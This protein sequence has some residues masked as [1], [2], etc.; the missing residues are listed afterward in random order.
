MIEWN[1]YLNQ[2]LSSS[3]DFDNITL[4]LDEGTC[5]T[6]IPPIVKAS[7]VMLDKMIEY[8]GR[9]NFMVF[10]EKKQS[11]IIF[12][13]MKLFNNILSGKI[14]SNYDPASFIAGEKLKIGNAVVE[15]L[16][17]EIRNN[18]LCLKLNL[19]DVFNFSAPMELLPVFQK[20]ETKRRL[21]KY[22]QFVAAKKDA[23]AAMRGV[24]SENEKLAYIS[25]MKTHLDS[26]IFIMSSIAAVK[27]QLADL[28]I[29]GTKATE[30]FYIAQTDYEG[31][32]TNISPGQMSGIPAIVF[33]S[34]LYAICTAVENGA[35]VQ[36]IIIDASNV[37]TLINQLDG[38]DNLIKLNVPILCITDIANSFEIKS[39]TARGFNI[40]RWGT[41]TLTDNLYETVPLSLD[42][43]VKNCANQSI[44]YLNSDGIEISAAMKLLAVHRRETEAQSPQMMRLF[45]KLSNLTFSA[46]RIINDL[47]DLDRKE[48]N[49]TL[50]ECEKLLSSEKKAIPDATTEDYLVII[51]KLYMVYE[52]G[53]L[54]KKIKV[55]Q[56]YLRKEPGKRVVLIVSEKSPRN[57]IQKY[58][59]QWCMSNS[60]QTHMKVMFPFEYYSCSM[61]DIDITVI[62][63]WMKKSIMRKLIYSFNTSQYVILLYNY[64]NEWKNAAEAHW[65]R[66]LRTSDNKRIIETAFSNGDIQVS[67]PKYIQKPVN[68]EDG[69][70]DDEIGEIE[71]ILRKNNTNRYVNKVNVNGKELVSVIPVSFVGG[72]L[73]FFRTN[74]RLISVSNIISCDSETIEIK[75]P[76]ELAVGDFIVV[77]ET[78]KDIIRELADMTLKNSGKENL[79]ELATIWRDALKIELAFCTFD[80]LYE[81]LK[82]GGC[83]KGRSTIKRWIEDEEVI[84]PQSKKDLEIIKSVTKN[85]SLIELKDKMPEAISEVRNA[86][87]IAGRKLSEQLK[88]TIAEELKKY[89]NIDP[90]IN[91]YLAW[92]NNAS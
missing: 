51:K 2:L 34:D 77:R 50:E 76:I 73:A 63:G 90:F 68:E 78:E 71:N 9:L 79:R 55:L 85:E 45:E 89:G 92:I 8:Q 64:E 18:T 6:K 53:F 16:G 49:R 35:P 48:A 65:G 72:S 40:W 74:H 3:T 10:P 5:I 14:K 60:F 80:V 22:S 36:S 13:L 56:D 83:D 62:C 75:R 61:D 23:L 44:L 11:M 30:T 33:A 12:S 19:A 32:I 15:Y 4:S 38:L 31:Q 27:K 37:N 41:D 58:W 69:E 46:L 57:Q 67:T 88:H 66:L 47:S 82:D 86:H 20:V 24:A 28:I 87:I 26:S 17:T 43:K 59:N 39:Y 81:K 1:E 29:D 91:A 84:A 54:F 7:I 70:T 52:N 25:K 42:K 21:S